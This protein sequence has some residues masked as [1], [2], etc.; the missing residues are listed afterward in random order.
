MKEFIKAAQK[1]NR[2]KQKRR[3]KKGCCC[4]FV[5]MYVCA[6]L[7]LLLSNNVK[8]YIYKTKENKDMFMCMQSVML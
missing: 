6:S 2:N 4:G 8:I 7:L 5:C 3:I 1:E